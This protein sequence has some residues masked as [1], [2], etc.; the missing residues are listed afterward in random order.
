MRFLT[1]AELAY[2]HVNFRYVL[3]PSKPVGF[4]FNFDPTNIE[5]LIQ[6]G[7]SDGKKLVQNYQENQGFEKFKE[8]YK[9][10]MRIVTAE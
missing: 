4:P 2:P 3:F 5:S 6:L 1:E 10:R 8:A 7:M 9:S